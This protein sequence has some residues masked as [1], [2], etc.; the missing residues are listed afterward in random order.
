M[1]TDLEIE[2]IKIAAEIGGIAHCNCHY[3]HILSLRISNSGRPIEGLTVGE[4]LALHR[5]CGEL[6]NRNK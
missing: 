6:Y 5:E 2:L 1:P 4:L 3:T